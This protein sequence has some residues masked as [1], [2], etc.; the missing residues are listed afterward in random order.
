M[1]ITK[2]V[3]VLTRCWSETDVCQARLRSSR[4]RILSRSS[5]S[6]LSSSV[7]CRLNLAV[8]EGDRRF[9]AS[10]LTSTVWT[11]ADES[12]VWS[13]G[14]G[15]GGWDFMWSRTSCICCSKFEVF[16]KEKG[17]ISVIAVQNMAYLSVT[18][19]YCWGLTTSPLFQ[20]H[21]LWV[22]K[23]L[24]VGLLVEVNRL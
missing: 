2:I 3:S 19:Q 6:C 10:S 17:R 7:A 4:S 14:G 21:S 15:G 5:L 23:R 18:Y 13:E 16:V 9:A 12:G 20:H 1:C 8:G 11:T 24:K 22:V